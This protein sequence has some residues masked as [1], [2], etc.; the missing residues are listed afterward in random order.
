[1]KPGYIVLKGP[2]A[3]AALRKSDRAQCGVY[4]AGHG[5]AVSFCGAWFGFASG[6]G[7]SCGNCLRL[8]T[9][10]P[11]CGGRGPQG[12]KQSKSNVRN[13]GAK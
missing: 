10:Q 3:W 9:C 13:G 5:R 6:G 11:V 8:R 4:T 1:M 2:P 12:K 7:R